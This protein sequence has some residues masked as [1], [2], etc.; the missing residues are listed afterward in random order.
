MSGFK[1]QFQLANKL[2]R[3]KESHYARPIVNLSIVGVALGLIIMIVA[4]AITS[5]YKKEIRDK[6]IGMGSHIRISNYDNNYSFEPV[7]F[8]RNQFFIKDLRAN[9]DI[10]NLQ[11][12]STKVGIIKTS[13]QVEGIVLKGIDTSFYWE[14]FEKN[15]IAGKKINVEDT[16]PGKEILISSK[17]SKK[18]KIQVG[19]KVRTYF[20]QDP[21]MQRSFI[22]SGIFETGLPEFDE[23][24]AL[25][26]LRH[27]Q[28]LNQWDSNMVG[29]IEI[30][31]YD[32]DKIDEIGESINSSIGYKLKAE[33]IKQIYPE[34][35]EWIALFDTNV[36]VLL[37]I[38]LFV[39]SITMMSTFFI[40]VLEQTR[41]IG[42]LKTIGIKNRRIMNIFMMIASK[43]LL[44]GL[45]IGDAIA[46]V[47]CLLQKYF[48]L[49]KLDA[50]TYYVDYIP[51]NLNASAIIGIN[52]GVFFLCL[53]I[54]S[55]PAYYVAKK[56]AP[57]KA[58]RFD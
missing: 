45:I 5:G 21:P 44:K 14:D 22:V 53:A 48:H 7:P 2:L 29:G 20:V 13:D 50:A 35:F 18:L 28:K 34:I 42:I 15:I 43:I 55:L 3:D 39:C 49:I 23:K 30:L 10:K 6:V 17:L 32:Y 46:M 9:P 16:Q 52:A 51:I 54:L 31:I 38:T 11:Y 56:I 27:V 1:I 57:V 58:I 12:F 41:T 25:V 26:D 19:D 37:I 4:I 36:L 8:E 33:T 47:I 24:F 40:I